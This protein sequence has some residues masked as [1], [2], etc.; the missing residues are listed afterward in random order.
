[1]ITITK[2]N[3]TTTITKNIVNF[4]QCRNKIKDNGVTF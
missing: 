1:M 4:Q 3:N 2:N